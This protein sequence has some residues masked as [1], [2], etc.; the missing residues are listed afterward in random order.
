MEK[1]NRE[2]KYLTIS[3]KLNTIRMSPSDRAEAFAALYAAERMV[4]FVTSISE[5]VQR[6]TVRMFLRPGMGS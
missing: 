2:H 6:L 1:I 3:E 4:D 5:G